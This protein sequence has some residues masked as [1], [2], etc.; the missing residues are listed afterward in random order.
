MN[1]VSSRNL[2][3][4]VGNSFQDA[5]DIDFS[6]ISINKISIKDAGNDCLDVSSGKYFVSNGNFENCFDK[7]ISVGEKSLL[8]LKILV[9]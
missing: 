6:N 4:V 1:I 3:K 2:D 5:V 9:F 8:C 7:A